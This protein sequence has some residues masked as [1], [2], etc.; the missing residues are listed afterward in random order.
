MSL[1]EL[2]EY[3]KE[4]GLLAGMDREGI[5]VSFQGGKRFERVVKRY[6][7]LSSHVGR[8]SFVTLSI[9]E[10]VPI[11]VIQSM[12]GHKD[13]ASFQKYIKIDKSAKEKAMERW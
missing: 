13:L 8:R 11:P 9:L 2:N 7:S 10:G 1:Q 4:I 5:D 12:T 3:L 6:E